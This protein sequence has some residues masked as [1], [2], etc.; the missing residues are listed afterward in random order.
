[1]GT[2]SET[3]RKELDQLFSSYEVIA[4]GAFVYLR[5]VRHDYSRWS[6]SAVDY[7]GLPGEYMEDAEAVWEARVHPEDLPTYQHGV[8]AIFTG[9][10]HS[11]QYRV[12]DKTGRYIACACLGSVVADTQTGEPIYF[13]GTITKHEDYFDA[14]TGLRNHYG[15]MQDL[16]DLLDRRI[17]SRILM[18]G[19]R[20]FSSINDLYGYDFGNLILQRVAKNTCDWLGPHGTVYRLDGA[21]FA[22]ISQSLTSEVLHS[23]YQQKQELCQHGITLEGQRLCLTCDGSLADL[24]S[25][26]IDPRTLFSG[27]HRAYYISKNEREGDLVL[28]GTTETLESKQRLHVANMICDSIVNDCHGFSLHYQPIIFAQNESLKGTEA[29]L[30][31]TS[32]DGKSVPP[33]EFI[34]LIETDPLFTILGKW[35]MRQAMTD[36]LVFLKKYPD[37]ILNVNLS[38][39]QI[40]RNDFVH[41]VARLLRETGF[42]AQ[43]LCLEITERC[44]VLDIKRLQH[45]VRELRDMGVKFAIDDFGTGFSSIGLLK[46]IQVETIKVDRSFVQHLSDSE[47]DQKLIQ[48]FKILAD[49][50]HSDVCAEGVETHELAE[51]LRENGVYSLQGFH[52]SKPLPYEEFVQKYVE[53][54]GD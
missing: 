11:I 43:N 46:D 3:S 51:I 54:A 39:T 33:N 17:K 36:G 29:L 42:P 4:P 48:C 28:F 24:A 22:I 38:Y 53:K 15:F 27:L 23:W 6:K 25:F 10:S 7:F 5:D 13:C 16:Q 20:R 30:R 12:K 41:S 19:F 18:F 52:F 47:Q 44:R 21:K 14:V 32:P 26:N 9:E 49:L 31:W 45:V 40:K 2:T 34:P 35:I 8:K 1:M 37:F 50:F